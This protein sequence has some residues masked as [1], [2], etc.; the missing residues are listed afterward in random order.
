MAI[1]TTQSGSHVSQLAMYENAARIESMR[2]NYTESSADGHRLLALASRPANWQ[3][4]A[5]QGVPTPI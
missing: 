2:P 3:I 4:A 1:D 5:N